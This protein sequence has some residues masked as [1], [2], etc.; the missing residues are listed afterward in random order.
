MQTGANG[1]PKLDAEKILDTY[2]DKFGK[3]PAIPM[4]Q[5]SGRDDPKYLKMLLYAI[6]KNRPVTE[7][8]EEKFFPDF[9]GAIY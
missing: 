9:E 3:F 1:K 4:I 7:E 2:L 6:K 8:D 5:C